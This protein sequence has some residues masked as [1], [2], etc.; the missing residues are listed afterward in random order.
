MGCLAFSLE[1]L[2]FL[3]IVARPADHRGERPQPTVLDPYQPLR[4]FLG[5]NARLNLAA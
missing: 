3:G 1:R 5:M 4:F 2:P